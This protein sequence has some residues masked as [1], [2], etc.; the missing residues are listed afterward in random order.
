VFSASQPHYP[1]RFARTFFLATREVIGRHGL[2]AVLTLSG[3]DQYL[4]N[5]PSESLNRSFPY[6]HIAALNRG[7]ED[8]Y[9]ARGGRG[10]AQRIGRAWPAQGLIALG[11][12][13]GIHD[14]AFQALPQAARCR[15]GLIALADVFTRFSDQ[16]SR[17]EDDGD[18][19]HFIVDASPMA[20]GRVS[21][22]PVC[23]ALAGLLQEVV[24]VAS[25]G[26]EY[27][28]QEIAC[29]AV[30]APACVFTVARQPM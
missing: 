14:P 9:G 8:M 15:I 19:Y 1:Q 7:L 6:A 26:A 3:L 11:A 13:A 12:L 20:F 22:K 18:H 27:P 30:G 29:Q 4:D 21:D 16:T 17:V 10:M 5:L 23:A 28:V 24:H 2:N 25:G